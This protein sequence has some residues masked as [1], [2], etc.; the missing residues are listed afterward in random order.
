MEIDGTGNCGL[1]G[2][3][4]QGV[5]DREGIDAEGN[6][7]RRRPRSHRGVRGPPAPLAA[8]EQAIADAL[9]VAPEMIWPSRY[10]A[11]TGNAACVGTA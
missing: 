4:D 6:Q 11:Q 8:G 9:G 7:H 2:Q 1:V 5:G 3:P 10:A